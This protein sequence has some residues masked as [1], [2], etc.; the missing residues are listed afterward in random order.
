MFVCHRVS[1]IN[2]LITACLA[3][4]SVIEQFSAE[5]YE[6]LCK[7]EAKYLDEVCR[8]DAVLSEGQ[9]NG[10]HLDDCFWLP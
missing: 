5:I 4:K 8:G 1:G 3:P 9:V 7:I 10:F 2:V 6:K